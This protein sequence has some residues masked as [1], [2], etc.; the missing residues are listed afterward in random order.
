MPPRC[1]PA[2]LL[3]LAACATKPAAAPAPTTRTVAAPVDQVRDR[4]AAALRE[5]GLTPEPTRDG[6]RAVATGEVTEAWA[7]CPPLAVRSY[8]PPLGHLRRNRP[9]HDAPSDLV[10]PGVRQASVSVSLARDASGTRVSLD[11]A[12]SATYQDTSMRQ[13]VERGCT[14]T[15]VLEGRLLGAAA[16]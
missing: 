6:L 7:D 12:F 9:R 15:G 1:T 2:L 16:G 3:L 8:Q 10:P 5:L 14:S 11:P 13:P 4:V